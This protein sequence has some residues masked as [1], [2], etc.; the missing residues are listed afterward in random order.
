M[1]TTSV[2]A[3]DQWGEEFVADPYPFYARMRKS[4]PV[5]LLEQPGGVG[6]WLVVG[7]EEARA[8][9]LDPR[10]VKDWSAA[11]A[12]F[13]A[14]ASAEGTNRSDLGPNMLTVDPPHH[15]RLRRLVAKEFTARRVETMRPQ[16]QRITDGLLDAMAP[17]GRAD[18]VDALAFPLPMTVICELLGVPFLDREAFREW[19]NELVAPTG[20]PQRT[21]EAATA[22]NAYLQQLLEDK[23]SRPGEDLMSA[24]I[25]AT[26]EDGDRLT[27]DE[28]RA[29]AFL[30]LVAGHETTV[31]LIAGGMHALLTH[32]EQLA[33]LRADPSLLDNAVEEM[34]RYDGPVENATIR[35]A[36]EPVEIA[37]TVLPAGAPVLIGMAS[38]DRDPAKYARPDE[39]DIRR[40]ASGHLAFGHG[41]HHCLGAPLARLE[42]RIAVASLLERFPDLELDPD[43]PAPT[44][45]P[46]MLIRGPQHLP[47]RYSS[48]R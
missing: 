25:R 29:M 21:V 22:M 8:A 14:A 23:R 28:L 5:H 20:D 32:P 12:A 41:I 43:A 19:S 10:L 3:M 42:G 11:S 9:F 45:R 30:L 35:F 24:L 27:A 40:D 16:V 36:A 48:S 2:I 33:A 44:W 7:H 46:G 26:D 39:F 4:G 38:A 1:S 37:G 47:V 13:A 31:N 15:T 6:V 34:L 18:L 17:A